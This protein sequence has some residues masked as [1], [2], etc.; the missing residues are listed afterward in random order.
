LPGNQ[1]C[2]WA[3]RHLTYKED[4]QAVWHTWLWKI[5][6]KWLSQICNISWKQWLSLDKL[7]FI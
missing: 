6:Q 1:Q 4:T 3:A 2:P 5:K 7:C